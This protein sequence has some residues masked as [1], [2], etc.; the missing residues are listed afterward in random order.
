MVK[1]DGELSDYNR[2]TIMRFVWDLQTEGISTPRQVKYLRILPPIAKLLKKDFNKAD[3]DDIKRVVNQV[4]QSEFAEWT[5][6]DYRVTLKRFYRWLRGLPKGENPPETRWITIGGGGKRILPE[7]LLTPEDITKIVEVCE[8]SRN[9]ALVLSIYETGGRIGEL[10]NLR[11]KHI[12]FD[13]YGAFLIV[14]GKTGDRRV[15][16]IEASPAL[17]QWMNDH[18]LNDPEAPLWVNVGDRNHTEP[19][20]YDWPECCF[21]D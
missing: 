5:K 9:R 2:K 13:Q 1:N 21:A 14:S 17:A 20:V 7:E 10:L 16:I 18:P 19:L 4:N 8:N 11:R 15:R 3:V 6:S 12:Q